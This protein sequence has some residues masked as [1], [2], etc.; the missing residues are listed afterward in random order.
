MENGQTG[1]VGSKE[2]RTAH[3]FAKAIRLT[4]SVK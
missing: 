4:F 2:K 3:A 1:Q